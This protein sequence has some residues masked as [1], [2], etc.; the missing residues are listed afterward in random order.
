MTLI[1]A[2][3][4]I[5]WELEMVLRLLLAALLGAAIGLERG[6]HGRSAGLRTHLLVTLGAALAMAVSLGFGELYGG[7]A[8]PGIRV[9]PA[10]VAY[11]VMGGI[12]FIGAGTIIHFGAGIRGLTTA[13]SLWCAAAIGLAAGLGMYVTAIIATLVVLFALAVL[14]FLERLLPGRVGRSITLTLPDISVQAVSSC[15]E[16]L[17]GVGVKVIR[18]ESDADFQAGRSVITFH[19]STQ[20]ANLPKAVRTL[21]EE[22]PGIAQVS[23]R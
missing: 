2:T 14:D 20:P 15:R 8:S 18:V 1:G 22:V 19:V 12:G 9:D 11:G 23:V 17:A 13:A 21:Q 16:L 5:S 3:P 6:L 7:G 4:P 10:R